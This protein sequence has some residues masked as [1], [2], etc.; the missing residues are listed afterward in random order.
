MTLAH[1]GAKRYREGF[2]LIY[3]R[4]AAAPN[5]IWRADHAELDLWVINPVGAPARPWLTV[6]EDDYSRA[7]CGFA[8]SLTA[9]SALNTALALRQAIWRKPDPGWRIC[10]IPA[11]F[12]T[13]HGSDFTS[14]HSE[15]V[16][17]DLRVLVFSLP[18]RPAAG[19]RSSA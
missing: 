14:R 11:V 7:I 12:H 19:A 17:A 13:D 9:P 5:A 18:G 3:R 15:Q 10:R 1:E 8:V 16:G 4:E 2:D 6:I